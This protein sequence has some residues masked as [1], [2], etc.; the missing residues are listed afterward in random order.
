MFIQGHTFKY[1][2]FEC[3]FGKLNIFLLLA[4]N[5]LICQLAL[6]NMIL[7]PFLLLFDVPKGMDGRSLK[8]R[9][10][11]LQI[12]K[13]YGIFVALEEALCDDYYFIV[14]YKMKRTTGLYMTQ[15]YIYALVIPCEF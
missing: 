13:S 9:L 10:H 14:S 4:R 6:H 2:S 11:K 8:T 15:F 3:S 1:F 7:V 5:Y 12:L